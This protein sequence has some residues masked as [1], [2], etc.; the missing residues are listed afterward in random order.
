MKNVEKVITIKEIKN[1]L[2]IKNAKSLVSYFAYLFAGKG[3]GKY[4]P[5]R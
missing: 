4:E 5:I 1:P 3:I 2:V